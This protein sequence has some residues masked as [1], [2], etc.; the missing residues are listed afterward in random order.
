MAYDIMMNGVI[1][2]YFTSP[3]GQETI[4]RYLT[5][6]EG[7]KAIRNYLATPDGSKAAQALFPILLDHI[8]LPEDIRESVREALPRKG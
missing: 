7:Q 6:A 1:A 2:T 8:G 3:Q 5:S 4:N